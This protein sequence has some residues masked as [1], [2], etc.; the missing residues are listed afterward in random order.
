MIYAMFAM[1]LL[2]FGIAIYMLIL[3]V[4]AVRR[5]TLKLSQF[6][7]NASVDIP[8]KI[9]QVARNYSNLFEVPVLFYAAGVLAIALHLENTA[10][11]TLSWIFVVARIAHTAIHISS[12]NVIHRLQAFM[13]ANICVLVIWCMLIWRY[14]AL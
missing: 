14:S 2:T 1:I 7:L 9:T 8:D 6:R 11:L 12:N 4:S 10:I 13:V 5:G 3:R